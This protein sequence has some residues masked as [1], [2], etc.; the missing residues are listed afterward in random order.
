MKNKTDFTGRLTT[1]TGIATRDIRFIHTMNVYIG[2]VYDEK[3]Y[4]ADKW[5]TATWK[6]SGR[7]INR[8]RPELDL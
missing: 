6:P 2:M 1:K 7:C 4:R 8:N 5:S 3:S